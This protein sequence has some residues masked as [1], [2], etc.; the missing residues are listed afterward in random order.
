VPTLGRLIRDDVN[1][2]ALSAAGMLQVVMYSS[3]LESRL[4]SGPAD[5]RSPVARERVIALMQPLKRASRV[6]RPWAGCRAWAR[7][8]LV[9]ASDPVLTP[10]EGCVSRGNRARANNQSPLGRA[11]PPA[12]LPPFTP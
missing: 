11:G 5:G 6:G 7:S 2:R 12:L 1:L 8:A 9:E 3:Q 4:P 10:L